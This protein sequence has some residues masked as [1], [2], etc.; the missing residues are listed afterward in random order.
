MHIRYLSTV[1]ISVVQCTYWLYIDHTRKCHVLS[2]AHCNPLSLGHS[3]AVLAV[4]SHPTSDSTFITTSR[5]SV[6]LKYSE[7]SGTLLAS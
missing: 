6:H 7:H 2:E 1:P 4:A 5:V 3:D